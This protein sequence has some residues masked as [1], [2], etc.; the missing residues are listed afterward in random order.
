[1][2]K[3]Q[4]KYQKLKI[5]SIITTNKNINHTTT[6][7]NI[8]QT[9]INKYLTNFKSKINLKIFNQTTQQLILTP[10]N[11]TLLP[12][13]N[14]ILNKNKQL[15]NFITNYKHKKHNQITIYTPTNIITYLSKHIINKIK[16]INNI[17]LSL[18]TY[19]LKHNTFYKN[20]KFPNNYNILINYTP[21]KNKSLIT[22]FI[23]QYTITTYTNQ[24]YLKKHPINHPNKLKHHSYILINSII[25]NNTNI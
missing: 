14:N 1:M 9:N 24:H 20:I 4:L 10:F 21:P 18:K 6:I 19:N 3:L 11:T 15:N 7:L 13:I 23:T 2:T 17:T 8:T 16:N 25:I 5:I 12:Y 22:N